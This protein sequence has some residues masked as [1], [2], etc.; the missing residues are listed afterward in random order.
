MAKSKKAPNRQKKITS[1]L[2]N[3]KSVNAAAEESHT[4]ENSESPE[5][6]EPLN[7]THAN[8][9]N[10]SN[11]APVET[12]NHDEKQTIIKASDLLSTKFLFYCHFFLSPL[13]HFQEMHLI[14]LF[15]WILLLA[16]E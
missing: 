6:T 3:K 9:Q 15:Y 1:D 5:K 11:E 4:I 10:E 16:S 2:N 7:E 13:L 14:Q 12:D 8:V